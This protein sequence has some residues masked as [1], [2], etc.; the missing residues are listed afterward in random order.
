MNLD[1]TFITMLM[2][3]VGCCEC[4]ISSVV[5]RGAVKDGLFGYMSPSNHP[6]RPHVANGAT[7]QVTNHDRFIHET[8]KGV[9][10][11]GNVR[12]IDRA[13]V[14]PFVGHLGQIRKMLET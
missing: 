10:S 7:N 12:D 6:Y 8:S 14:E 13:P 11:V 4:R 9:A 1:N 5:A 3:G 2:R